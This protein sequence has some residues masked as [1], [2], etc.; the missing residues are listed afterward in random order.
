MSGQHLSGGWGIRRASS[1]RLARVGPFT[2]GT[3]GVAARRLSLLLPA[4]VP[5]PPS[6]RRWCDGVGP[7][8]RI[9]EGGLDAVNQLVAQAR[10]GNSHRM[11]GRPSRVLRDAALPPRDAPRSRFSVTIDDV[12][13]DGT[14]PA[15]EFAER[16]RAW[17]AATVDAWSRGT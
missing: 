2:A 17:A 10:R 11:N 4:P 3:V 9:L 15:A 14:F 7:P 16:V 6:R 1:P 8:T 5:Q 13:V 12:A